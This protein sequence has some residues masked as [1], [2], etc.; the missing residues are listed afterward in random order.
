MTFPRV[1]KIEKTEVDWAPEVLFPAESTPPDPFG[2]GPSDPWLA[3]DR[4]FPEPDHLVRTEASGA[5]R[6]HGDGPWRIHAYRSPSTAIVSHDQ[7]RLLELD[8]DGTERDLWRGPRL[9]LIYGGAVWGGNWMFGAVPLPD[10]RMVI[11]TPD[12]SDTDG[13]PESWP[14]QVTLLDADGDPVDSIA[15]PLR[16]PRAAKRTGL[17]RRFTASA[18]APACEG[19]VI[20]LT[21]TEILAVGVYEDHLAFVG[22]GT[23]PRNGGGT[24]SD[25]TDVRVSNDLSGVT[26]RWFRL[27]GLDELWA[28]KNV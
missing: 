10:G 11:K 28:K 1:P 18:I 15:M 7:T 6:E 9:R 23:M 8:R 17:P 24:R 22:K 27:D 16:S 2:L 4:R 26:Y 19:R 3:I 14:V 25:G 12:P 5:D 13:G 21:E 20:V